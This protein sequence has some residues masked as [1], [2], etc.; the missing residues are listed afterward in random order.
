MSTEFTDR[1]GTL[2]VTSTAIVRPGPKGAAQLR[3]SRISAIYTQ[4][5]KLWGIFSVG[6]FD[7]GDKSD[8]VIMQNNEPN[9]ELNFETADDAARFIEAVQAAMLGA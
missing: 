7:I 3:L 9:I 2:V 4:C 8:V 6:P 1:R 5:A